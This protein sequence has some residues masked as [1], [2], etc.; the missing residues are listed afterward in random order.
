MKRKKGGDGSKKKK[1]SKSTVSRT[2]PVVPL[3]TALFLQSRIFVHAFFA[4]SRFSGCNCAFFWARKP[5]PTKHA[6]ADEPCVS[7]GRARGTCVRGLRPHRRKW[8]GQRI[9][10]KKQYFL[11]IDATPLLATRRTTGPRNIVCH[12]ARCRSTYT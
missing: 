6:R 8:C 7:G 2:T 3:H 4:H 5:L 9:L 12:R 10:L 11:Y 1:K